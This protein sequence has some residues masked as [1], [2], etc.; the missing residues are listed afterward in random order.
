MIRIFEGESEK[1]AKE[2]CGLL[3]LHCLLWVAHLVTAIVDA[4]DCIVTT[5]AEIR[6]LDDGVKALNKYL[7]KATVQRKQDMRITQH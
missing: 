6:A 4:K 3:V 7:A 1:V 5:K 2:Q